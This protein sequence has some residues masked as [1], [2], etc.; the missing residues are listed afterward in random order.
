MDNHS[1]NAQR[2]ISVLEML[3]VIALI[4]IVL[5][6]AIMNFRQ[7]RIDMQR[8]AI[9]RE[10]KVYLERARFDSVKRRAEG[11]SQAR[12]R[13]ASPTSFTAILDL[14]GDG[15]LQPSEARTVNFADQSNTQILVTDTLNYPVTISF[16]R[17]GHA[18]ALDAGNNPVNPV[19]TI[20]SD[21]SAASPGQSVIS[22][23]TTGTVAVS[24]VAPDPSGLP[25]PPVTNPTTYLNCY[26]YIGTATLCPIQ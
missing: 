19:F 13:L 22:L 10:F 26:V 5:T 18:T 2:G 12:L 25:A 9:V 3:I 11:A 16:D 15:T 8:Q 17:R 24:A 14:N 23:S 20:C 1:R 7:P 6:L 21:C 4:G